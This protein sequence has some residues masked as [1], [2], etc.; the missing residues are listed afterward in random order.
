MTITRSYCKKYIT[1]TNFDDRHP[2]KEYFKVMAYN[3]ESLSTFAIP[4]ALE[5]ALNK[6]Y[7]NNKEIFHELEELTM[8]GAGNYIQL[9][10]QEKHERSIKE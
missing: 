1:I 2:S 7:K 5:S 4:P 6:Y 9:V 8:C 3:K 10:Y